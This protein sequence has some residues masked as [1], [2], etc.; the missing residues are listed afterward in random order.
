M[1]DGYM[2]L[3]EALQ[4]VFDN[5]PST[6]DDAARMA[7][8]MIDGFRHKDADMSRNH[9]IRTHHLYLHMAT[10]HAVV[11]VKSLVDKEPLILIGRKRGSKLCVVDRYT[12][13]HLMGDDKAHE[14]LAVHGKKYRDFLHSLG[15]TELVESIDADWDKPLHAISFDDNDEDF[16]HRCVVPFM[17]SEDQA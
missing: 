4:F 17:Q 1:K 8:A 5:N 11:Y 12:D 13:S 9:R 10:L 2:K 6:P 16:A 15:D 3:G 7:N 14:Y